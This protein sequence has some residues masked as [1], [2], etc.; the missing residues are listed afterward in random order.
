MEPL[1]QRVQPS[2][3]SGGSRQAS[4]PGRAALATLAALVL[5]ACATGVDVTTTATPGVDL[6]A[7]DTYA[8]VPPT[9]ARGAVREHLVAE[10]AGHLDA[11]GYRR[12]PLGQGELIVILQTSE[13]TAERRVFADT[14]AGC[15]VTERYVTGT[16]AIEI[17]DARSQEGIW[18][19]VAE[20]DL[21][22]SSEEEIR[23]LATRAASAILEQ[24]P[25]EQATP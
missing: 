7:Y 3:D 25:G 20:V 23:A 22:D 11:R 18:R 2:N 10:V 4:G 9:E 17:F 8:L 5:G 19:G 6:A 16:L 12:A 24:L 21:E 14:P 13:R 15:C 1:R